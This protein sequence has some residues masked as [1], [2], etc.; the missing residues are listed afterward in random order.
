MQTIQLTLT[1]TLD[2]ADSILAL[3]R[4]PLPEPHTGSPAATAV[5]EPSLPVETTPEPSASSE[6]SKPV[7]VK[8]TA[9]KTVRM[10]ALGRT[11]RQVDTYAA[12]RATRA[13]ELD[14]E[15]I[16]K[17]ERAAERAE[18]KRE[19]EAEAVAKQAIID[20]SAE[21]VAVIKS[22]DSAVEFKQP[23]AKPD[24]LL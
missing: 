2:Q 1:V 20:K 18:R 5:T 11:Q 6:T 21:E 17:A 16:L 19:R 24:W 9:G 4:S 10:P 7:V 23:V 3:L 14:E 15:A 13:D 22:A 8:P 12:E